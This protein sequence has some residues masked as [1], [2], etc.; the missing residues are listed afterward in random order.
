MQGNIEF[1]TSH[2]A[3]RPKLISLEF[4][5][6]NYRQNIR[7]Y[8][9][10]FSPL[11]E[12]GSQS[13]VKMILCP[14]FLL[15]SIQTCSHLVTSLFPGPRFFFMTS[16]VALETVK[17]MIFFLL[18]D[19]NGLRNKVKIIRFYALEFTS[20]FHPEGEIYNFSVLFFRVVF[21]I[22]TRTPR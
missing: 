19:I 9:K 2:K 1:I 8:Q 16:R 4:P 12:T 14:V 17:N 15:G 13:R 20:G 11:G 5:L 7:N 3:R 6:S 21:R 22:D 18:A 10:R